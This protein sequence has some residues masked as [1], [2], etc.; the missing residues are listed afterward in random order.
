MARVRCWLAKI[1]RLYLFQ[2]L[3]AE[4]SID[5]NTLQIIYAINTIQWVMNWQFHLLNMRSSKRFSDSDARSGL[6]TFYL[7]YCTIC[8]CHYRSCAAS[9]NISTKRPFSRYIP[10]KSSEAKQ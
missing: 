3:S 5:K 8:V 1:D 2:I 9:D 7:S 6:K 4:N 10:V